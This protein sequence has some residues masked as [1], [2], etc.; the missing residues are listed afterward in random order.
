MR[1]FALF[2]FGAALLSLAWLSKARAVLG[3]IGIIAVIAAVWLAAIEF[4]NL[5]APP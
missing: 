2:M 1:Y 5:P 4:L 3:I